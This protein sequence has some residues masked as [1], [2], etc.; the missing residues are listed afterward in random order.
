VATSDEKLAQAVLGLH[1]SIRFCG[2]IKNGKVVA[3]GMRKGVESLE[4]E[5]LD[6]KLM[7][8]LSIL[9]GADKGWDSYLGKTDYFLIRKGKVNL[10]LYPI[11]DL[12]GVLVSTGR[13]FSTAKMDRIRETVDEYDK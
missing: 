13:A 11:K 10:I 3:G 9:I 4:P 12:R 7:T 2:I 6:S 1:E 5:S 8:Q